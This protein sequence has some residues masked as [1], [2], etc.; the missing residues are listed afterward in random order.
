M[1]PFFVNA[2]S[3]SLIDFLRKIYPSFKVEG[4]VLEEF[5]SSKKTQSKY[6][7]DN[8]LRAC[9]IS[10]L[11]AEESFIAKIGDS[12][13]YYAYFGSSKNPKADL[14]PQFEKL[15]SELKTTM[16]RLR[17]FKLKPSTNDNEVV[18]ESKYCD[19]SL[20]VYKNSNLPEGTYCLKLEISNIGKYPFE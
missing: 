13:I 10:P 19:I 20:E 11:G 6:Y 14:L 4:N 5:T 1:L 18:Y 17:E 15:K 2:Q 16:L 9:T 3:S 8:N 7:M 12:K